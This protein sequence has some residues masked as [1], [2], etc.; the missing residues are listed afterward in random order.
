MSL[1]LSPLSSLSPLSPLSLLSLSSLSPLSL[2]SSLSLSL[3]ESV[4]GSTDAIR[5]VPLKV[6]SSVPNPIQYRY[7]AY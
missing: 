1:G 5:Y 6:P 2:L 7:L 3:S 4:L